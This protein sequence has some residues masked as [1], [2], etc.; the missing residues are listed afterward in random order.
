MRLDKVTAF[1]TRDA[2]QGRELLLFRHPSGG[3]QLPAGTAE[4]NE[5][6]ANA[7]LREAVEETG[8][9][10]LMITACLGA[11]QLTR[12]DGRRVI[13]RRTLLWQHAA[14]DALEATPNFV[15]HGLRRGLYVRQTGAME[16]GRV[17]VV[18]E[19]FDAVSDGGN[20][21]PART[22]HG[23]INATD[24]TD[25]LTRHFYHLVAT[26]PTPDTWTQNAEEWGHA[27]E[28]FW[29]PLAV[30]ATLLIPSQSAWL[31]DYAARIAE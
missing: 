26:A 9:T 18:Y 5:T 3:V 25:T 17:P 19:E 11:K 12:Q 22:A 15:F 14:P 6:T 2:P 4:E 16:A 13:L 1:V 28:L 21:A 10:G 24:A 27:F 8:L 23:W 20:I 30:A 29:L 7:V 31:N